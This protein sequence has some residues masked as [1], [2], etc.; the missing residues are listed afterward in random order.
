LGVLRG[1]TEERK[2][3]QEGG[4]SLSMKEKKRSPFGGKDFL[5]GSNL[6][7]KRNGDNEKKA[8]LVCS[9]IRGREP[10]LEGQVKNWGKSR[11]TSLYKGKGLKGRNEDG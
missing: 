5:D 8:T 10:F 3:V 11:G 1:R 7:R 2:R 4:K 6:S 9:K